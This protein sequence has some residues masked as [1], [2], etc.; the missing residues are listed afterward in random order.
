MHTDK[1]RCYRPTPVFLVLSVFICVHLWFLFVL[2]CLVAASTLLA[3]EPD[4]IASRYAASD[5]PS[6]PNP[7]ASQRKKPPRRH[8]RKW[9]AWRTRPRPPHRNPF[10][11]DARQHLLPVHLP[12]PGIA[13]ETQPFANC[14]DQSALELGCGR[15]LRGQRFRAHHPLQRVRSFPARR[16]GGPGY[17]SREPTPRRRLALEFRVSRE[18]PHRRAQEDLV[19]RDAHSPRFHR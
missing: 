2:F 7:A 15:S 18:G 4:A 8:C 3:R 14:R 16:M 9:P 13:S 12:L 17:R 6:T 10:P 5:F 11:L 19:W 1:N